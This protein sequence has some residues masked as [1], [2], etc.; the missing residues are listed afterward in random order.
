MTDQPKM[1]EAEV[2][3]AYAEAVE[4]HRKLREKVAECRE[5]YAQ[6]GLPLVVWEL[7]AMIKEDPDEDG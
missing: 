6:S 3:R 5:R 7:I 4:F 1:T 2:R